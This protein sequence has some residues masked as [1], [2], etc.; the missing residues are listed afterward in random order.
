MLFVVVCR[1]E[2]CYYLRRGELAVALESLF[3]HEYLKLAYWWFHQYVCPRCITVY[4]MSHYLSKK[5]GCQLCFIL[6]C[7]LWYFLFFYTSMFSDTQTLVFRLL[8][9]S[10]LQIILLYIL[11][12]CDLLYGAIPFWGCVRCLKRS[13][14]LTFRT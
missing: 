10:I 13:F 12:S 11:T 9:F 1:E 6:S 5:W 3:S 2:I 4:S 14:L 8:H 7:C